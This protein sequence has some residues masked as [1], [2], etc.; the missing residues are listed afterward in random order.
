M[1]RSMHCKPFIAYA[2]MQGPHHPVIGHSAFGHGC[3]SLGE[4]PRGAPQGN[5]GPIQLPYIGPYSLPL[6]INMPFYIYQIINNIFLICHFISY[7][8]NIN[9]QIPNTNFFKK[10]A[11]RIAYKF[12]LTR[13]LFCVRSTSEMLGLGVSLPQAVMGAHPQILAYSD[14]AHRTSQPTNNSTL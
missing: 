14:P 5:R 12:H 11:L 7:L 10:S 1:R 8:L 9:L 2:S 6:L 3:P 4:H 13:Y